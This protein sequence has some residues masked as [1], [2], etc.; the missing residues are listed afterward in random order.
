MHL[1]SFSNTTNSNN[2]NAD[3]LKCALEKN[4]ANS[5]PCM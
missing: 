2:S 3:S 4:V 5:V 1:Q